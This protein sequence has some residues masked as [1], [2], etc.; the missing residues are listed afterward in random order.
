[1]FIGYSYS[2]H[3][4]HPCHGNA[5]CYFVV[6]LTNKLLFRL[7]KKIT[8]E[9][10]ELGILLG[11]EGYVIDEIEADYRSSVTTIT[12]KILEKWMNT[13]KRQDTNE[14]YKELLGALSDMERNDLV[15]FVTDG[16]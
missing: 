14:M 1:M 12:L 13:N 3:L 9:Y 15:G 7:S 6:Y 10:R 8:R 2:N 16:E 4:S 11:I 5:T